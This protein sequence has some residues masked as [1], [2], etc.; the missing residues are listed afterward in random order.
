MFYKRGVKNEL[1]AYT[2]SDYAGDI[3]DRRSTSGYAFLFSNGAVCWSSRKQ[4]VVSLSTTESE[5]IAAA[6]CA[7]QGIWMKR[8]LNQIGHS[9]CKYITIFSL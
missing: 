9:H 3:D 1:L 8:M 6:A 7:C 5:F 2:D 4:P